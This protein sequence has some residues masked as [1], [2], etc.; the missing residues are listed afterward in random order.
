[1]KKLLSLLLVLVTLLGI[2]PTS[3]FAADSVEAALGEVD[4][5]NGGYELGY[6]S[7]N[8]AV[9]KQDYTY[10]M[11]K[12]NDG[13]T[14]EVPA[15]C[16]NPYIK[17]VPQKVEPGQ[18]IKYLAE[19][20]SSDPKVVGII[21][22]GYPHR[23]LGELKLDNKYQAYYATK[24]AL[25]CYLIPSW[26]INNLKVAPGLTGA[27]L[28]RG[29]RILAAAK[30]IY[31]RGTTYNYMLT[32]K[33]TATPDHS[34]AYPVSVDGKDYYQQVFTVWS[35]TWVYDYDIS[36][37]FQDPSAV[38]DGTRIVNMD[39]QDVTAVAAEGTGD[40]YSAQ[41]KVLYPAESIQ[42]QSGSVQ[43]ALSASVA[44][45]AAMYAVCQEKDKYGDLQN[46]ICDL[47]NNVRLDVAAISNYYDGQD[48]DP[49]E[50]ALK[51]V[52]L[53]EGTEIPLEGA[54]FS[55]YDPEGRKVG[56][57][58]TGPDGTVV[59]PLTLEGHYTVTEE[60]PPRYHLLPD[61]RTQHA[62]VEYN[63]VATLTFWNAPY[64]SLRVEKR[65]I[66]ATCFPA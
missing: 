60:L 49:D 54:V 19:E 41:F 33:M 59:I 17:G 23:S 52:K 58:S 63:K 44:Q 43:L 14:R 10:F 53:E 39:N 16:V 55:V 1:M 48:P 13:V 40:G 65:V 7:I 9:K 5:Y 20:R 30:D 18:S 15:Y 25:W 42:N 45:Y 46:Y 31:K 57:F 34:V 37:A 11:Y 38:P 3:A 32:P 8:G 36:V 22:N 56:S 35:E 51:I 12:G 50:T 61:E 26:N 2:I 21:S 24:M 27:E 28:D 62:D 47:D 29:N 64:G 4:I 6:L 66:P